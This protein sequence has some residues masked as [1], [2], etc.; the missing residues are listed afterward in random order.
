MII[1][2]GCFKKK[3]D[4]KIRFE[5]TFDGPDRDFKSSTF[6]FSLLNYFVS[7][8]R[9]LCVSKLFRPIIPTYFF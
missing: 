5:F 2:K 1:K 9:R 6:V 4:F 8:L 3:R 7:L